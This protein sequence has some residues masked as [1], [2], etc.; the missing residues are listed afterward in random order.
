MSYIARTGSSSPFQC[1]A[2][3]KL[4]PIILPP[5]TLFWDIQSFKVWKIKANV[6]SLS[7]NRSSDIVAVY[8]W[9]SWSYVYKNNVLWFYFPCQI[10]KKNIPVGKSILWSTKYITRVLMDNY[11]QKKKVYQVVCWEWFPSRLL[12]FLQWVNDHCTCSVKLSLQYKNNQC[13]G[14]FCY[15]LTHVKT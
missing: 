14:L 7:L 5:S 2:K 15:S 8:S 3:K 1:N 4:L 12:G 10:D 11:S 13:I 6:F 9:L